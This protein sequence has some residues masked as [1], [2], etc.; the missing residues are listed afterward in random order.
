MGKEIQTEILI[1]TLS[2]KIW[3]I[4]TKFENYPAW[5]P[6]IKSI[7]GEVKVGNK[8]NVRIEPPQS[9]AMTFRPGF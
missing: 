5:N 6:F 9:K 7:E 8:I 1:N 3:S 4:L 2:E